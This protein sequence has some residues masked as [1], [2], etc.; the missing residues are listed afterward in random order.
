MP[1]FLTN[2]LLGTLTCGLLF[3]VI[4]G[5]AF[6]LTGKDISLVDFMVLDILVG[7]IGGFIGALAVYDG[8]DLVA[9]A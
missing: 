5:I 8:I 9:R 6:L 7:L 1:S 2:W 4:L 3:V